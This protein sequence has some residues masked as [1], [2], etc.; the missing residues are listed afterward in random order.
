MTGNTQGAL[1]SPANRVA[2]RDE[3][4]VTPS[5]RV[6]IIEG[7]RDSRSIVGEEFRLLRA[8]VQALRQERSLGCIA[9]VSAVPGEGKSTVAMGLAAAFARE[10][11]KRILLMEGDLRRP[12]ISRE[13]GLTPFAGLGEWL[14]GSLQHASVRLVKGVG[15]HLL[16]AGRAAL[17]RPEELGSP[18]M[19]ALLRASRDQFDLVIIDSTPILPVA[20]VMLLQD[21]VDGLLYVVRSRVTPRSAVQDA[22]RRV[23]SDK[24][25]GV[26]LNDHQE[27]RDSY[28]TYAYR[29]YNMR[30]DSGSP[31]GRSVALGD[32]E[33]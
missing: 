29:D 6:P 12:T 18:R 7:L 27:Y 23:R 30:N 20:D 2:F 9:V 19:E 25:I 22:L 28:M 31:R 14:N 4:V 8:K 21:L 1:T 17:D 15:F 13:L 26:V 24:L 11:G 16:G 5:R 10:P 3:G 32:R 33:R